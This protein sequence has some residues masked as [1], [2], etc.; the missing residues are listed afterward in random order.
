MLVLRS[1]LALAFALL[2]SSAGVAVAQEPQPPARRAPASQPSPAFLETIAAPYRDAVATVLKSPTLTAK[3][4]EDAFFGHPA[5]YDWLI[6]HPDR[7]SLAWRRLGVPCV[8]IR[9]TDAGKFVWKDETGS[10][11][12]WLPVGRY[13][14]GVVWYATGKVK[15]AALVPATAVQAVAILKCTRTKIDEKGESAMLETSATVY[16]LTDGAAASAALR[17]LGPAVPRMAEQGAEQILLFFS[18]PTRHIFAFPEEAPT[19][20]APGTTT[21]G[22]K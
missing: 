5:V 13:G 22:K 11:L 14:D 2:S 7:G 19:L 10:E 9:K 15:P 17:L 16:L 18:G 4:K 1:S 3:A 20:L 6:D 12:T 21:T 8:E